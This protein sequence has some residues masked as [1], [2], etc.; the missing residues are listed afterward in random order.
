MST[1]SIIMS[2]VLFIAFVIFAGF[3]CW[4][5]THPEDGGPR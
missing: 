5:D 4:C 3:M 2:V 1:L